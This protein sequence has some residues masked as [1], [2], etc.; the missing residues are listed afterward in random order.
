VSASS[1]LREITSRTN[2]LVQSAVRLHR[3]RERTRA[4]RWLAEGPHAV[5]GALAAEVVETLFVVDP[6]VAVAGVRTVLVT[7][8]VLAKIVTAR[9]HQGIAAICRR[10]RD[11]DA[12]PADRPVLCLVRAADPGNVGGAI[13]TAAHAG[14][15][16]VILTAGSADP[17]GPRAARA[18]A[19]ALPSMPVIAGLPVHELLAAVP[20]D[21][22]VALDPSGD[23][24]ILDPL[25][26]APVLVFGSEAHGLDDDLLSRCG[27]RRVIPQLGGSDVLDSL[28]LGA[29]VAIAS[30]AAAGLAGDSQ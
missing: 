11:A 24:S 16:A 2:P 26:D 20:G 6:A 12:I 5:A 22:L 25:P 19:G 7:D 1:H 30:Y 9:T 15:A 3:R 4:G 14:L 29:A 23:R 21:R 17:F 27:H 10:P 13:R 18:A 28:N 8:D